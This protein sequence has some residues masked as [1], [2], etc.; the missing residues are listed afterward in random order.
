MSNY[1]IH[2][3]IHVIQVIIHVH[4]SSNVSFESFLIKLGG[5]KKCFQGFRLTALLSNKGKHFV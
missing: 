2:V 1:V 4:W 5:V 3:A